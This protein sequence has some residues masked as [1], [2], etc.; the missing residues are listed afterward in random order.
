[1]KKAISIIGLVVGIAL[2]AT[3]MMAMTGSLD[4]LNFSGITVDSTSF[5]GDFYT[6]SYR[7]TRA[8]GVNVS[9]LGDFLEST[10]GVALAVAGL[11]TALVSLY[12]LGS[13]IQSQ[14]QHAQ[15]MAVAQVQVENERRN[16][17]L[18]TAVLYE[19]QKANQPAPVEEETLL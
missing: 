14:N 6:Y 17:E 4:A 12:G 1:M 18:L 7:A 10:I 11:L 8:A 9:R 19:L 2:V 3:G 13:A 15:L 5:G 16:N